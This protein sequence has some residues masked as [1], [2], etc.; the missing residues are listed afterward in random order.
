MGIP[1]YLLTNNDQSAPAPT[2][3]PFAL[4]LMLGALA[5]AAPLAAVIT[6]VGLMR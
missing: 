4:T 6:I 5:L 1:A 2:R 3:R